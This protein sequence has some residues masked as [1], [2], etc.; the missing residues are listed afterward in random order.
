[1]QQTQPEENQKQQKTK[2][3]K[4]TLIDEERKE[5]LGHNLMQ[6]CE[7]ICLSYRNR[8]TYDNVNARILMVNNK[9]YKMNKWYRK[10]DNKHKRMNS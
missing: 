1:M 8:S 5:N 9:R 10:G 3:S 2:G 4:K 6:Q 7:E